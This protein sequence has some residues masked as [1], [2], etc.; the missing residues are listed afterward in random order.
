MLFKTFKTSFWLLISGALAIAS[1]AGQ[2]QTSADTAKTQALKKV[3]L[4][5]R[6]MPQFQFAGYY[7][8][9]AKGFYANEGLEVHI[10]PGN[11]N[12]T[13]VVEEVLTRRADFG[14]GNSGLALASMENQPVTVV[15]DI[16]QRSA[17]VL[18][19]KPGLEKSISALSKKNMALRNIK[20]N[21]ELYG[22]FNSQGIAP[23]SIPNI[24]SSSDGFKEFIND[25]ADAFNAYLGNETYLLEKNNIA[26]TVIDPQNYGISFY[27]DAIF[28]HSELA[29]KNPELVNSFARASIKGW[30][31]ALDHPDEAVQYLH[32]GP[33]SDRTIEHLQFEAET[34]AKL[35]MPDFIPVGQISPQRWN[36]IANVFKSL[37]LIKSDASLSPGFYLSYWE[38][39]YEQERFS[40][41]VYCIAAFILFILAGN[42]WFIRLNKKL[43]STLKEKNEL[44]NTVSRMANHDQLT[45]LPNRR[46][47]F[48]RIDRAILHAKRHKQYFSVCVL[49][50]NG[51]KRVN[52]EC[53]HPAGDQVLIEVGKRLTAS[54]RDADSAGRLGGDEFFFMNDFS[55][56]HD[57]LQALSQRLKSAFLTPFIVN[58]K[59]YAISFS[60]GVASYPDDAQTTLGL[61]SKADERMYAEKEK[62]HKSRGL[63][64]LT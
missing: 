2:A 10:I 63:S 50:L 28:T 57:D 30:I 29:K 38:D 36:H 7:M 44:I 51:F 23:S 46:L 64:S 48:D 52:D 6:W 62:R 19:T 20:D 40:L 14:I 17:A 49:D 8:A 45:G 27:G 32:N 43:K 15:A 54:L 18:I 56:Y 59:P 31:Y 9:Q 3:S 33:A 35:V 16:F 41:Y 42:I 4:Q 24:S 37:N 5:L 60:L 55:T 1:H 21:P 12:R 13:Q 47:L 34:I 39:R 61:I 26:H 53:G 11:G 58:G 25:E 22:I